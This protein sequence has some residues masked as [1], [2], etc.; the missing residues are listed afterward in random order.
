MEKTNTQY[1]E[2]IEMVGPEK[3]DF[4]NKLHDIF[5]EEGC[6]VTIKPSKTGYVVSYVHP[7]TKKTVANFAFRKRGIFIRIY[8]D[9][10]AAYESMLNDV[11]KEMKTSIKKASA[12]K[13]LLNPDACN[14]K[15]AKGFEFFMDGEAQQKCRY[16]AFLFFL[17]SENN[18]YI[19]EFVKNELAAIKKHN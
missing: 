18:P 11:S 9:N 1:I 15:C 10:V 17:D 4:T 12:C 7:A 16:G 2:F 8:A 14:S 3:R 13:R 6:K 19:E 5:V